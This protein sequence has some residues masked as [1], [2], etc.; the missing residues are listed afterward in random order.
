MRRFYNPDLPATEVDQL[1]WANWLTL[2]T[3]QAFV[4]AISD[5]FLAVAVEPRAAGVA[6]HV[7]L[8]E[9]STDDEEAIS[10]AI[11]DLDVL[12]DGKVT[13][14]RQVVIG[15]TEARSWMGVSERRLVFLRRR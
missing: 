9:P 5:N 14:D 1:D 7:A 2:Q 12:L 8:R 4:G 15:A 6:V 11:D 3:V 10:D 13:I